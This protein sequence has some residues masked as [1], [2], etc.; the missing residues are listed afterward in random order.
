MWAS[1]ELVNQQYLVI[2]SNYGVRLITNDYII[3]KERG[4][5]QK[6]RRGHHVSI[7]LKDSD[8]DLFRQVMRIASYEQ[9]YIYKFIE[10]REM[11]TLLDEMCKK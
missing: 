5:F 4:I 10:I 6:F 8:I 7:I 3:A 2:R 1:C 9:I 11:W